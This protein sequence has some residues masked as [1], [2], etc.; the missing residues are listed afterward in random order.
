[1]SDRIFLLGASLF[2][3]CAITLSTQMQAVATASN[4][5]SDVNFNSP[6]DNTLNLRNP[7]S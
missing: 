4:T 3:L 6:F 1:M 7:S 5:I 2:V